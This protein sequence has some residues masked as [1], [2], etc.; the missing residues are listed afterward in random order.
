MLNP[1]SQQVDQY[2]QSF[3][4]EFEQ[5]AV[6]LCRLYALFLMDL[7]NFAAA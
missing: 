1:T 7:E 6:E 4:T 3:V 5:M 2:W